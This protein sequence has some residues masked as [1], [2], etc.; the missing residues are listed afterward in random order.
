M[1]GNLELTIIIVSWNTRDILLNCIKSISDEILPVSHQIIVVD[2]ASSDNSV[3]AV[4]ESFPEVIVIE[5]HA[6]FG[7]AKANNVAITR[8]KSEYVCLVNSDVIVLSGCIEALL[9]FM[10]R[11]TDVGIIGPK[12]L[13]ADGSFQLS[14]KRFPTLWKTLCVAL[15]LHKL[16]PHS[17]LF[18]GT[19]MTDLDENAIQDVQSIAGAFC[20]VRRSAIDQVGLLDE[21]FFFYGEDVDWCK[22]FHDAGF[23]V[24]YYPLAKAVHLG[25]SSS[26]KDPLRFNQELYSAKLRYWNKHHSKLSKLLF[27]LIMMGHLTTRILFIILQQI[28]SRSEKVNLKDKLHS[29]T[30]GLLFYKRHFLKS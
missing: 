14:C 12:L 5:N 23:R 9:E 7:F 28:F 24:I 25:G 15:G 21:D 8:S 10:R 29:Y 18:C 22:R 30:S 27:V 20:L 2:N 6:N 1:D 19:Q 13:N 17:S 26:S 4:R 16:F 11:H 3:E